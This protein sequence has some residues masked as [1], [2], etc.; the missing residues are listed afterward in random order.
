MMVFRFR[1]KHPE[2]GKWLYFG[3]QNVPSWVRKEEVQ[4]FTGLE[5]KNGTPIFQG[6]IV[7]YKNTFINPMT[8]RGK[9]SVDYN[10]E[11]FYED[12]AFRIKANSGNT[13]SFFDNKKMEVIG[14]I[15]E[16]PHLLEGE[17]I[18]TN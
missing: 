3:I 5:D 12:G 18:E 2:F 1:A 15:Y 10:R 13:S 9:Q 7:N 6:D 14:N 17:P 4:Q 11:V 8:G 16:H